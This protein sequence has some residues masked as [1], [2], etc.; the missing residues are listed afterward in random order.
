MKKRYAADRIIIFDT[1][2]L[3]YTDPLVLSRY[4]DGVLLVVEQEKTTA[5]EVRQTVELLEDLR[6][7]GIVLNKSKSGKTVYV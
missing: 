3:L 2:S 1:P 7:I 4:I 5:Q 6:I